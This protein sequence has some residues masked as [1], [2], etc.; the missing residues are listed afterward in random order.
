[1]LISQTVAPLLSQHNAE[2]ILATILEQLDTSDQNRLHC[3]LLVVCQVVRERKDLLDSVLC[4]G[5]GVALGVW[6]LEQLLRRLSI[7]LR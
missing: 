6:L 1:M 4:S 7:G 3:Q 2:S 5:E